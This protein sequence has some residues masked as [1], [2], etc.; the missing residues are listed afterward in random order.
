MLA[1]AEWLRRRAVTP[2]MRVRFSPVNPA[3][4]R[5]HS[6]VPRPHS[7]GRS[8]FM[9]VSFKGKDRTLRT[10]RLPFESAYPYQ[11][12]LRPIG[13]GRSAP[14]AEIPV[15]IR[16]AGPFLRGGGRAAKAPDCLSGPEEFDSLP[17]RQLLRGRARSDEC[18]DFQSGDSR[19]NSG[20][21][22]RVR[23]SSG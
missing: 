3:L 4:W 16:G 22:Y 20:L 21:P 6:C 15:R 7:W 19:F 23:S 13:R 10:F 8:Y 18:P 11:S 5:A 2:A 9:R 14:N 12:G 1:V 17:S